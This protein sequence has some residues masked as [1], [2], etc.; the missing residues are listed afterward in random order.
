ME[1]RVL[2]TIIGLFLFSFH[3]YY[4]GFPSFYTSPVLKIEHISWI[5]NLD[6]T[7][8][9]IRRP[10]EIVSACV[11]YK[12]FFSKPS[13]SCLGNISNVY[14]FLRLAQIKDFP[15]QA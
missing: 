1:T 13:P 5:V 6:L 12:R 2:K 9:P 4:L 11:N 15:Q 7:Y 3:E 14:M 10:L 8:S